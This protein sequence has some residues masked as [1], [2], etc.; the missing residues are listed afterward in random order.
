MQRTHARRN[1]FSGFISEA[2]MNFHFARTSCIYNSNKNIDPG[3]HNLPTYFSHV[4]M[5]SQTHGMQTQTAQRQRC[6]GGI[7]LDTQI[8]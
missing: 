7:L 2:S 1:G 3:L 5:C 6:E 4:N 8:L